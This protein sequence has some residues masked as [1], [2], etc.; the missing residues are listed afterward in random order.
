MKPATKSAIKVVP[1]AKSSKTVVPKKK[2]LTASERSERARAAAMSAWK[3]MRSPKYVAA[4]KKG[5]PAVQA[6]LSSRKAA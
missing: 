1:A 3:T 6:F 5:K 2:L 4:A